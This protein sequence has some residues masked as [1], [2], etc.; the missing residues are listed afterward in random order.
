MASQALYR[1]WRSQTF[2]TVIGQ[3]HVTLTLR[4]A[5]R[6]GRMTHAY[7]FTGP[8]G[9]GKTSTARIVAKALNCL[10]EDP[11]QRP[12][13]QCAICQAIG[14]GRLLDLIEIDAASNRGI[15]EIRDLREKIAFRPNQARYKVY[16]ID[17]VHMLTK[18]AFNALLK[19]LEEPPEHAIFVLATT[20]PDRVP[21]TVRSRCQRFDFRRIPTGEIVEHLRHM[22]QSEGGKAESEALVA[23]AR[24]STGSMRDSISLLDQL[25][26]YGDEVLT[27][28]RV[29]AVL[30]L[31]SQG[32]IGTLVDH[33][34]SGDSAGGLALL[35]QLV[36]EGIELGQLADQVVAYL[37]GVLLARI[38]QSADL[39]D[40]SQ[41]V[42]ARMAKQAQQINTSA[43]LLAVKEWSDARAALRDQ[44]PGAPQL[45]LEMA[46]LRSAAASVETPAAAVAPVA[47]A[48]AQPA[49]AARQP[50]ARPPVMPAP[51]AAAPA[52]A[53]AADMSAHP[54][55]VV[56]AVRPATAT[57]APAP[58]TRQ[59]SEPAP[60]SPEAVQTPLAGPSAGPPT[61]LAAGDDLQARVAASWPQFLALSRQ[62]CG[63]KIQAALRNVKELEV[64]GRTVT[65]HFAP[66]HGFSRDV[67]NEPENKTKVEDAWRQVLG[68][69]VGIRCTLFGATQAPEKGA[70]K[71]S[72][73]KAAD[74]DVLLEEAKRRGAIITPLD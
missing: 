32:A 1:K 36:S 58:A 62:H 15:D 18:E 10:H 66:A 20:E 8:R 34:T 29:E 41:D 43:L 30:G 47:P 46:F 72:E 73:S 38:S 16:I 39:L 3:E 35:N 6:D 51:A 28:A 45:P 56:D 9:T 48:P 24:R 26:S 64:T 57:A 52:E 21:E 70:E 40:L 65:L 12:C 5:L 67:I 49:L 17:E 4:N 33:M 59:G 2:E 68:T 11:A 14:E 69:D 37:R 31:V 7:L 60:S 19:T 44:V 25:L 50:A 71:R 63:I 13:N 23:I 54:S 27:A 55:P 74:E 61:G 53:A 42:R 22:V